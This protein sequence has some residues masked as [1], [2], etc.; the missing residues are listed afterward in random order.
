MDLAPLVTPNSQM[1]ALRLLV[2]PQYQAPNHLLERQRQQRLPVQVQVPRLMAPARELPRRR[3][4]RQRLPVR[5]QVQVRRLMAPARE[6]PQR[7]RSRQ[8]LHLQMR[9]WATLWAT[10]LRASRIHSLHGE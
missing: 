6:V 9:L 8:R 2:P 1:I 3:R 10:Q 4:P 7:Q 5:V